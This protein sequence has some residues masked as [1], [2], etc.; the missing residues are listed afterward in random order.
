MFEEGSGKPVK[1]SVIEGLTALQ[2]RRGLSAARN[3]AEAGQ[4]P[5]VIYKP[6]SEAQDSLIILKAEDLAKLLDDAEKGA[7]E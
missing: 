2:V 4:L 1:A 7:T 3:D 5:A 6:R